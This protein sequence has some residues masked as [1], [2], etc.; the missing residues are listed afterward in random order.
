MQ[1]KWKRRLIVCLKLLTKLLI[2]LVSCGMTFIG[3]LIMLIPLL[4]IIAITGGRGHM[5]SHGEVECMFRFSKTLIYTFVGWL[6]G[7]LIYIVGYA[8]HIGKAIKARDGQM[9]NPVEFWKV[10][11]S[12]EE[13]VNREKWVTEKN[14][15]PK[16]RTFL[17]GLQDFWRYLP[18]L[19]SS[20]A[21]FIIAVTIS[22][23]KPNIEAIGLILWH[24]VKSPFCYGRHI[25]RIVSGREKEFKGP[26]RFL[27]EYSA[28]GKVKRE[29]R[30][31]EK[32]TEKAEWEDIK[33]G[34][35]REAWIMLWD[36]MKWPICYMW[37]VMQVVSKREKEIK[38]LREFRKEYDAAQL[39]KWKKRKAKEAERQLQAESEQQKDNPP[40][41]P[42]P[43]SD[44]VPRTRRKKK[45]RRSKKWRKRK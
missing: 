9:M 42:A 20:F 4:P 12:G 13:F 38:S 2:I 43:A 7:V 15:D 16:V 22:L 37:Y 19:V 10:Y 29:K 27:N 14:P 18:E 11:T 41:L 34:S 45:K 25:I 5:H 26:K 6:E 23:I 8:K 40:E 21:L 30:K 35:Q 31:A 44:S 28:A 3:I 33:A 39:E 24:Y 36:Y 32:E 17:R 1:D